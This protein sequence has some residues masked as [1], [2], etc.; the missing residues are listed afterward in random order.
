MSDIPPPGP[1]S[2]VPPGDLPPATPPPPPPGP[3]SN[4]RGLVQ[5][6]AIAM[7][8]MGG[9]FLFSAVVALAS[10]LG[11]AIPFIGGNPWE[12]IVG[13][14]MGVIANIINIIFNVAFGGFIF[15]GAMQ[16]QQLKNYNLVLAAVIVTMLPCTGCC[17]FW[18][19]LGIGIWGLVILLRPDV[20]AAFGAGP[21][22]FPTV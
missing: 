2:A 21:S 14:A 19:N 6:P 3:P 5:G 16:M 8:I 12:G 17:C 4:P 22:G 15:Y 20:K 10:T 13:H 18:I 9:L 1:P 11:F 7:M